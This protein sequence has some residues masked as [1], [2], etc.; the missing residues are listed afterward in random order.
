MSFAVIER[1]A[2]AEQAKTG[3]VA[4]DTFRN[5]LTYFSVRLE[6]PRS[7]L[8]AGSAWGSGHWWPD[9]GG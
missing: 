8:C 9:Y 7:G 6:E 5:N 3:S 4:G 2:T 1:H